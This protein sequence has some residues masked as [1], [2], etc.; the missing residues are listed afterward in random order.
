M[1][2]KIVVIGDVI[3]DV[4]HHCKNRENPESSAPCYTV[5]KTEYKPGGAGNVAANLVKLGSDCTLISVVGRDEEGKKLENILQQKF[6]VNSNLVVDPARTTIVKERYLSSG[7]GRYHFR[8]DF[9]KRGYID[10]SH[11]DAI[12]E[13]VKDYSLILISDYRK[14]IISEDLMKKLKKLGIRIIADTK[15]EHKD[16]FEG[17]YLIKPNIKEVRTMTG[18]EDE[19][20]AAKNLV[21]KLKTNVMLT[22]GKDGLS[23]FDKNTKKRYDFP[24]T[25]SSDKV[26][27]V[28]GAG[29]TVIATF[30]H[31][32][33][34]GEKLEDS[35]RLANI[36]GGISV[37][38]PG[39]YQVSEEEILAMDKKY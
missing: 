31:F 11:V 38:Y 3:L 5:E 37:Q 23:Y 10:V 20:K 27:D 6:N 1:T 26:F 13:K 7:D 17:V 36:A 16:F 19:L 12:I 22:R 29:D 14:G 21:G 15:P 24:P 39:C 9:E 25:V 28:T 35:I 18:I 32:F 34:K 2:G 4:Y 8:A 30:A 33:M